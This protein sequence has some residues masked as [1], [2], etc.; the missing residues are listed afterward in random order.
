M[1][2]EN[3]EQYY[4]A[5]KIVGDSALSD[6]EKI[7]RLARACQLYSERITE[8][9]PMPKQIDAILREHE[10]KQHRQFASNEAERLTYILRNYQDTATSALGGAEAFRDEMVTW[11]RALAICLDMVGNASTH[12]EKN[13]RLRGAIEVLERVITKL[14]EEKFDLSRVYW[15]WGDGFETFRSD[16]PMR[17]FIRRNN[18]LKREL[19]EAQKTIAELSKSENAEPAQE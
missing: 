1:N 3:I 5:E 10:D 11:L 12:S 13:A 6:A 14:K 19:E 8:L 9:E 16:Y 4:N 18:D 7:A 2:K 17:E 15:R